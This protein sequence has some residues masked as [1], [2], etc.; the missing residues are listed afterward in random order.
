M[1]TKR[2]ALTGMFIAILMIMTGVPNLGIITIGPISLTIMHIPVILSALLLGFNETLIIATIF[3]FASWFVALTRAATPLDLLFT[4]PI[5]AVLPR[6]LFGLFCA[7]FVKLFKKP[8][9]LQTI[10]AATLG[11]LTHTILVLTALILASP[12]LFS[13]TTITQ[14]VNAWI[15]LISAVMLSNGLLEIL[16]AVVITLPLVTALSKYIEKE[17]E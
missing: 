10:L 4:N 1:K 13:Y 15:A 12:T 14:G 5:V 3:G 7:L 9:K 17:K 16:A 8:S 2:I 6:F 11:T